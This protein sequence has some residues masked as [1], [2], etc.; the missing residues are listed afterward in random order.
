LLRF[1]AS[2][3]LRHRISALAVKQENISQETLGQKDAYQKDLSGVLYSFAVHSS[4]KSINH[5][6]KAGQSR[7]KNRIVSRPGKHLAKQLIAEK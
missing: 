6:N 5:K 1:N 4:T 3:K 7:Y 2:Q